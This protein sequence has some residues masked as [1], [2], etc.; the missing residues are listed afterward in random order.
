MLP[1]TEHSQTEETRQS[2]GQILASNDGG[3]GKRSRKPWLV[4]A[5]A[6]IAVATLL[7]SGIWSRVKARNTLNT[8]T[9]QAA[10]PAVSVVSPKTNCAH[11]RNHPARKRAT[12]HHFT[13]LLADE[14]LSQ[15]VVFRY[16]GACQTGSTACSNRNS[17]S[18]SATPASSQQPAD[19][20]GESR[21]RFHYQSPI[22]G[23][24]EE[25]RCI[26]TGRRQRGGCLQ[27]K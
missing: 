24:V 27:C 6:V 11:R 8:E 15:K 5:I 10:V 2:G 7:I 16:W 19:R 9:D 20:A 23:T 4:L 12:I 22:S 1:Q 17:G 14:W 18:R 26:P 21:A 3:A 25:Q 13:D